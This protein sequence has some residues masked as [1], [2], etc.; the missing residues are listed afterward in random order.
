MPSRRKPNGT[1]VSAKFLRQLRQLLAGM[2]MAAVGMA[3]ATEDIG[4]TEDLVDTVLQHCQAGQAEQALSIS[5]AIAEQLQP[6]PEI[7]SLLASITQNGCQTQP[8]STGA[9]YT[10]WSVVTGFDDN[11]NQGIAADSVTFGTALKPVILVLDSD[12]KPVSSPY[13]ATTVTRQM[14]TEDGWV[15]RG[16]LG[17]KQIG[18]YSQLNTSGLN[19]SARYML[20]PMGIPSTVQLGWSQSWLGAHLYRRVPSLEW[21]SQFGRAGENWQAHAQIQQ[22]QHADNTSENAYIYTLKATREFRWSPQGLAVLGVGLMRDLASH[23]RAGG[24][25][26]GQTTQ[27]LLQYAMPQGQIQLQWSHVRWASQ[28][29]FSP[30]LVDYP[31]QNRTTQFTLGYQTHAH[32]R[33]RFYLELQRT[34]ARDNVP[35][36]AHTANGLMAG[37][38]Q[39]WR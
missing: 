6:P 24:D 34:L 1:T 39:Q 29:D 27:A 7:L 12:Y 22:L 33:G 17:H 2:G 3:F 15:L 18:Q 28:K 26:Q 31:R 10:E 35:L 38:V 36:Y 32:A 19:L 37:W 13:I 20:Q 16:T 30:N 21:Q 4:Y 14:T 23:E 5:R 25:R 8:R 9:A 11:V